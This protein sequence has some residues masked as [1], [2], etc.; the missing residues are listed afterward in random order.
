MR[1]GWLAHPSNALS[2]QVS[3][4]DP[5]RKSR[6]KRTPR[7]RNPRHNPQRRHNPH[8]P[9]GFRPDSTRTRNRRRTYSSEASEATRNPPADPEHPSGPQ[10]KVGKRGGE[11]AAQIGAR[12]HGRRTAD[13]QRGHDERT[14]DSNAADNQLRDRD[15]TDAEQEG[16][17]GQ[18]GLIVTLASVEAARTENP[19]E[20][21]R[22][23]RPER[24]SRPAQPAGSNPA[25]E[26]ANPSYRAQARK[27][28]A[29]H[30]QNRGKRRQRGGSVRRWQPGDPLSSNEHES[31]PPPLRR[32]C[33]VLAPLPHLTATK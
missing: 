28:P 2:R 21:S 5:P 18:G 20:P 23:I 32:S 8:S 17:R 27:R 26:D 9:T 19:P 1:R 22:S 24:P 16:V 15:R 10:S 31:T 33:Y 30:G 3:G 4:L 25:W 7:V 11:A 12:A 29:K 13:A 6:R 14:N